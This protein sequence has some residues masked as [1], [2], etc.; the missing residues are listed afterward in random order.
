MAMTSRSIEHVHGVLDALLVKIAGAASSW[1]RRTR[2]RA[3]KRCMAASWPAVRVLAGKNA[4]SR[5]LEVSRSHCGVLGVM[6]ELVG[7][8]ETPGKNSSRSKSL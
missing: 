1:R 5:V 2:A 3:A 7:D 8:A 6:P 4:V